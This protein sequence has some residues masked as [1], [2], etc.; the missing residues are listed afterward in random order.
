MTLFAKTVSKTNIE[1]E[2]RTVI[3]FSPQILNSK[4]V[5]PVS[6]FHR[7]YQDLQ[8]VDIINITYKAR[9]DPGTPL[10]FVWGDNLFLG[11]K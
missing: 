9:G 6:Q 2:R 10:R 3:Q 11:A 8:M 1:I 5:I 4:C 7:E